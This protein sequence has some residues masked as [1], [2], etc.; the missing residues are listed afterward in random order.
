MSG[1]AYGTPW[2]HMV[3]RSKKV[4]KASTHNGTHQNQSQIRKIVF[5]PEIYEHSV[6][7]SKEFEKN[8]EVLDDIIKTR[9]MGLAFY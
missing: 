4:F 2:K 7:K 5:T 6:K 9:E 8:V 1:N 3:M